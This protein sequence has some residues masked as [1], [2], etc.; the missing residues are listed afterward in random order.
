MKETFKFLQKEPL[1]DREFL[2][3]QFQINLK[4]KDGEI[5]SW[6]EIDGY[7]TYEQSIYIIRLLYKNNYLPMNEN[8]TQIMV[9]ANHD[10][11]NEII[12][13]FCSDDDHNMYEDENGNTISPVILLSHFLTLE[14]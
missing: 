2:K 7:I 6:E 13:V 4:C 5:V 10:G 1:T 8:I 14:L 12:D 11:E 9:V 3:E